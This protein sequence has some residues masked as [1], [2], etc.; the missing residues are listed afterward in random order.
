V[1]DPEVLADEETVPMLSV[2]RER[3][4]LLVAF[5]VPREDV[6]EPVIET[7]PG[8]LPDDEIEPATRPAVVTDPGENPAS[9]RM[10]RLFSSG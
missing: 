9:E 2:G 8:D 1:R 3:D 6:D 4:G 7:T 5:N 10:L